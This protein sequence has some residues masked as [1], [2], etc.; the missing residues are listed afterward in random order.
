MVNSCNVKQIEKEIIAE[1]EQRRV[2]DDFA[3]A[4]QTVV[5]ADP[6]VE[7]TMKLDGHESELRCLVASM[8][9]IGYNPADRPIAASGNALGRLKVFVKRAIR[10]FL[11]WYINPVCAQQSEFNQTTVT[12]A[13]KIVDEVRDLRNFTVQTANQGVYKQIRNVSHRLENFE[14]IQADYEQQMNSFAATIQELQN[15]IR[16]LQDETGHQKPKYEFGSIMS[17]SQ[18]GEDTIVAYILDSLKIPFNK[19]T[20]LDLGANHPVRMNNSYMLYRFG[21]RGVLVEANPTLAKEL[22]VQRPG[23]VVL[24]RCITDTTGEFIKFYVMSGDGL[25][26]FD[27]TRVAQNMNANDLL[28]IK[29]VVNVETITMQVILDTYFRDPP[30]VVSVDI[31]G[32]EL[33]T[34][35]SLN[36]QNM[37]PLI[38]I[39]ETIEYAPHLLI[40]NKKNDVIEYMAKMGYSEYAFT[41]INSIFVDV[42]RLRL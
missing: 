2:R 20:Y 26:T 40:N 36:L 38:V 24:N 21:A 3:H 29:Q 18:S 33:T 22:E 6:I 4:V 19:C 13:S 31:E 42:N 37:R 11:R 35:E 1:N 10:K 9:R 14:R 23:D 41:G 15:E 12:A 17:S 27:E 28:Y 7:Q 16:M 39:V 30:V 5:T 8:Q 32:D 34:L 25:S